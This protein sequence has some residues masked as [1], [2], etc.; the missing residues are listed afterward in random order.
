MVH[1]TYSW[2]GEYI[3]NVLLCT[4]LGATQDGEHGSL[5]AAVGNAFAAQNTGRV[6][7]NLVTTA[8]LCE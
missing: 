2:Y 6:L 4:T 8:V 1:L 5:I 7:D 3:L